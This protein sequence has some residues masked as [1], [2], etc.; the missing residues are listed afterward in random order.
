VQITVDCID[1]MENETRT[2]ASVATVVGTNACDDDDFCSVETAPTVNM[3]PTKGKDET[4]LGNDVATSSDRDGPTIVR[5]DV[6]ASSSAPMRSLSPVKYSGNVQEYLEASLQRIDAETQ[7]SLEPVKQ[8][9]SHVTEGT[10]VPD[11]DEPKLA[12]Q[13]LFFF[14]TGNNGVPLEEEVGTPISYSS[15]SDCSELSPPPPPPPPLVPLLESDFDGLLD[16]EQQMSGSVGIAEESLPFDETNEVESSAPLFPELIAPLTSEKIVNMHIISDGIPEEPSPFDESKEVESYASFA[17]LIE[18]LPSEETINRPVVSQDGNVE[19]PSPFDET[20]H[21]GLPTTLFTEIVKPLPHSQDI[22][23]LTEV[24]Q[25][26]ESATTALSVGLQHALIQTVI[27]SDEKAEGP[28]PFD[29][30]QEVDLLPCEEIMDIPVVSQVDCTATESV[31]E[32]FQETLEINSSVDAD[33]KI[34]EPSP[35]DGTKDINNPLVAEFIEPSNLEAVDKPSFL[36]KTAKAMYSAINV[37]ELLF[38]EVNGAVFVG[39]IE[40]PHE[41]VESTTSAVTFLGNIMSPSLQ[42]DTDFPLDE[43][44]LDM[45]P[46]EIEALVHKVRAA[47]TCIAPKVT[48]SEIFEDF[49][50]PTKAVGQEKHDFEDMKEEL[51]VEESTSIIPLEELQGKLSNDQKRTIVNVIVPTAVAAEDTADVAIETDLSSKEEVQNTINFCIASPKEVLE[52]VKDFVTVVPSETEKVEV[53]CDASRDSIEA[54]PL[55]KD[56]LYDLHNN[57]LDD[58]LLL[59]GHT[60]TFSNPLP[61]S[62]LESNIDVNDEQ[63]VPRTVEPSTL[64]QNSAAINTL[65]VLCSTSLESYELIPDS[66]YPVIQQD[67][68]TD[69]AVNKNQMTFIAEPTEPSFFTT[70]IVGTDCVDNIPVLDREA[71][72]EH[73]WRESKT[74]GN[75]IITPDRQNMQCGEGTNTTQ[76]EPSDSLS[77][78]G[79]SG[80]KSPTQ[81]SCEKSL[82]SGTEFLPARTGFA[83]VE[84]AK[85]SAQKF[86][87]AKEDLLNGDYVDGGGR[88][89][90]VNDTVTVSTNLD[91]CASPRHSPVGDDEIVRVPTSE[92][93]NPTATKPEPVN[94]SCLATCAIM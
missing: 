93:S 10:P 64:Q 77:N 59:D 75:T 20:K 18:P 5:D 15:G 33:G 86:Q 37:E 40:S 13:Q 27:V 12:S 83:N 2:I 61:D 1:T 17:E 36:H 52:A 53:S 46:I 24:S 65:V 39:N 62:F 41:K 68:Q 21:L 19:E 58:E 16:R 69:E 35:F 7:T 45:S 49:S 29:E 22:L 92:E 4:W 90:L 67:I 73:L 84:Y 32:G 63:V 56:N 80:Q 54:I 85:R 60:D 91:S 66:K 25:L 81:G 87:K 48:Q 44:I 47:A 89:S 88:L 34:Q 6:I 51:I 71:M 82:G 55:G 79:N 14:A 94:T 72:F 26:N 74:E 3:V 78:T 9:T 43:E 30:I 76:N 31:V 23:D 8:H 38:D 50:S 70:E 42:M 11:Y 57:S 28:S